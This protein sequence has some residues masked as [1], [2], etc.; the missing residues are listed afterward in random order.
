[1][2]VN[3]K[4]DNPTEKPD[5]LCSNL[6]SSCV[7]GCIQSAACV[8]D[9]VMM[10]SV[11]LAVSPSKPSSQVNSSSDG[12]HGFNRSGRVDNYDCKKPILRSVCGVLNPGCVTAIMVRL[13]FLWS[14]LVLT[15]DPLCWWQG[16]SGSGKTTLLKLLAGQIHQ[17]KVMHLRVNEFSVY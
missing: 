17:G 8:M 9:V 2:N 16:P 10:S 14:T 15:T 7:N 12:S 5:G 6:A 13:Y 11:A 3:K 1:M 4:S